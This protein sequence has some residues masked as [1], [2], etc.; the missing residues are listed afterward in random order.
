MA[1][2]VNEWLAVGRFRSATDEDRL[3]ERHLDVCDKHTVR[4]FP[5]PSFHSR[6]IAAGMEGSLRIRVSNSDLSKA[7]T[8]ACTLNES[9]AAGREAQPTSKAQKARYINLITFRFLHCKFDSL[10]DLILIRFV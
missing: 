6:R 5:L 4:I 10:D 2:G 3:A 8:V 9:R 7:M 1:D